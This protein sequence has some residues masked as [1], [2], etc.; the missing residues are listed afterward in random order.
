MADGKICSDVT[1]LDNLFT[2]DWDLSWLAI[3]HPLLT[4]LH[5][6]PNP[7]S[8]RILLLLLSFRVVDW[9]S[10]PLEEITMEGANLP[11]LYLHLS[12]II[13][14][15]CVPIPKDKVFLLSEIWCQHR[16]WF[17]LIKSFL[18]LLLK[19]RS[20][21]VCQFPKTGVSVVGDSEP[22]LVLTSA[23]KVLSAATF[24][25]LVRYVELKSMPFFNSPPP[26]P[27]YSHWK[28]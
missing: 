5:R 25:S 27:P 13:C 21:G 20:G 2:L 15:W 9:V 11:K 7:S 26:P 22:T 24:K 1:S 8:G 6:G 17:L 18:Q 10:S 16:L 28:L 12:A 14:K 23:Y 3:G 19:V 4:T